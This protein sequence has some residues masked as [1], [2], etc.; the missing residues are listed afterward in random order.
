MAKCGRHK[1]IV[2][3]SSQQAVQMTVMQT[4][5]K[6]MELESIPGFRAFHVFYFILCLC[7]LCTWSHGCV[8]RVH[9][10]ICEHVCGGQRS[11]LGTE[12]SR[13]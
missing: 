5:K 7:S 2:Q 1:G 12:D 8:M 4:G 6:G 10:Y 3:R 9:M 11:I 13:N